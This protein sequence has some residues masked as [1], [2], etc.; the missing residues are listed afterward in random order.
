MTKSYAQMLAVVALAG[1]YWFLLNYSVAWAMDSG[2]GVMGTD[3]STWGILLTKS[4]AHFVGVTIVAL[5]IA[6]VVV[7]VAKPKVTM[8]GT[9]VAVPATAFTLL[10]GI[11]FGLFQSP[12]F[13]GLSLFGKDIAVL[14]LSVPLW[15]L[16]VRRLA[17]N[18]RAYPA[19]KS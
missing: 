13:F 3:S 12:S 5:P 6:V 9:L 10:Q 2:T 19:H 11:E 8:V 7:L 1:L 17:S 15:A 4:V 18:R 14:L 16:L